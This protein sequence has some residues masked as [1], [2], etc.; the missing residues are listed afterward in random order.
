MTVLSRESLSSEELRSVG[1]KIGGKSLASKKSWRSR[2][3][4]RLG[5]LCARQG[6]VVAPVS[7]QL[8][9]MPVPLHACF[10]NKG[11]TRIDSPRYRAWKAD[12]DTYLSLQDSAR[13]TVTGQV[14]V[15]YYVKRPDNRARDLDNLLKS[16]NDTLTR[17]CIIEDDSC[18]VDLGIAWVQSPLIVGAVLVEVEPA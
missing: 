5:A 15:R 11:K 8:P 10:I 18:I 1:R 4:A 3:R 13:E 6:E 16:L 7:F 12:T 2:K 14:R 9:T 17:N